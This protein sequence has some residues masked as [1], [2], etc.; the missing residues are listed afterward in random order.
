VSLEDEG[1]G[2]SSSA[3]GFEDDGL[4]KRFERSTLFCNTAG[5]LLEFVPSRI[6]LERS[7][8]REVVVVMEDGDLTLIA[9]LVGRQQGS[10]AETP[11]AARQTGVRVC[12]DERNR[13]NR[14]R[15]V[16]VAKMGKVESNATRE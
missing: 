7:R 8:S 3:G 6:C 16:K 13:R 10:M 5:L 12:Q 9:R 1:W 11:T 14:R 15:R 2:N 4:K